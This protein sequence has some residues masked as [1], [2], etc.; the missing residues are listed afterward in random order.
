MI[1]QSNAETMGRD[2]FRKGPRSTSAEDAGGRARERFLFGAS[3]AAK[4]ALLLAATLPLAAADKHEPPTP[5]TIADQGTFDIAVNGKRLA[6]ETFKIEQRN[7]TNVVSSKLDFDAGSTSASQDAEMDLGSHG[8]LKRY[9]W[10]EVKPSQASIV[11]EPQDENFLIEHITTDGS[12]TVK[13]VQHPLSPGT[14]ILDDNFFSHIEVLAWR[15][16]AMGCNSNSGHLDCHLQPQRF[17]VMVPHQGESM[18][19]EMKYQGLQKFHSKSGDQQVA[20][21]KI[22]SDDGELTFWLNHDNKL[23][24]IFIPDTATEVTRE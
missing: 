5:A 9:S 8:E 13:D 12:P 20:V 14:V 22:S 21:F 17:P 1:G 23:T 18:I 7:G 16:L 19:V 3:H 11:V 10:K 15:Y 6:T 4:V 2:P 24:R